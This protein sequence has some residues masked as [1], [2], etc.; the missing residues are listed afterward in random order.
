MLF[1]DWATLA[2]TLVV[3]PLGYVALLVVVRVAGKRTLAKLNAF[4]MVVTVALGSVLAS[5]A[6]SPDVTLSSGAAA[7]VLLVVLQFV[8]AFLSVRLGPVQR[9]VKAQPTLL[10]RDGVAL[11]EALADQRVARSE[12][13]QVLRQQ[14]VAS[15]DEAA[16]V[17]LET[18]GTFSVVTRPPPEGRSSTLADVA[19][20]A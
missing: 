12:I 20:W 11:D 19:G 2:R 18:D 14:G 10:V 7:L 1:E 17:V 16:A 13:L 5:V 8:I 3:G 15:M 4:D 9:L 6:V